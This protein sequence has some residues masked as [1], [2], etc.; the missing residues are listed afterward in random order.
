MGKCRNTSPSKPKDKNLSN[1]YYTVVS[2]V[3][4]V[5]W[6]NYALEK[7]CQSAL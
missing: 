1:V 5:M 2:L 3:T 7:I 6:K 4:V